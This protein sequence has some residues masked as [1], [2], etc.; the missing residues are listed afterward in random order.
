MVGVTQPMQ[1]RAPCGSTPA[2]PR[3]PSGSTPTPPLR[4]RPPHPRAPPRTRSLP[5]SLSTRPSPA[6]TLTLPLSA[7]TSSHPPR[8]PPP[9]AP[10]VQGCP[11][12]RMPSRMPA[13]LTNEIVPETR[14][15]RRQIEEALLCALTMD[16]GGR[17]G[18]SARGCS[19]ISF[20]EP[21]HLDEPNAPLNRDPTFEALLK[22]GTSKAVGKVRPARTCAPR[23]PPRA[24][25]RPA[26]PT[27]CSHAPSAAFAR[28]Q[29]PRLT[30]RR[31]LAAGRASAPD[32]AVLH[33]PV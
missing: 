8:P 29:E 18:G 5:P 14:H 32:E 27:A 10:Q 20:V 33:G 16:G 6:Q 13:S 26:R 30:V 28:F 12:P 19:K 11:L 24:P 25:A 15:E 22:C 9:P 23:A 4:A 21:L 17:A 2:P 3:V 1:A 7:L 31:A